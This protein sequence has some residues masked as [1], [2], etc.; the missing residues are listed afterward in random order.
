MTFVSKYD[1]SHSPA[2]R[3]L[4]Q[5]ME[6]EASSREEADKPTKAAIPVSH[7]HYPIYAKFL[8]GQRQYL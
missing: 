4:T 3:R 7:S 8:F 5:H 1:E 6:P 2:S